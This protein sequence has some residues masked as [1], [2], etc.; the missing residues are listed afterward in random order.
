MSIY[1]AGSG[2]GKLSTYPMGDGVE[3]DEV[4]K[5]QTAALLRD[6]QHFVYG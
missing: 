4:L 1:H 2:C 6:D 5:H 3:A